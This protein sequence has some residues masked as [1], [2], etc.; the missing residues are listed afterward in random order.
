[1]ASMRSIIRRK[2]SK[3]AP[4]KHLDVSHERSMTRNP[5][6]SEAPNTVIK[7]TMRGPKHQ[8]NIKKTYLR[9]NLLSDKDSAEGGYDSDAKVLDDIAE[10]IGKKIPGKRPSIHSIDWTPSIGR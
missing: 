5:T 6:I 4:E 10:H 2:F 1:M 3:D 8:P 7:H 9:D